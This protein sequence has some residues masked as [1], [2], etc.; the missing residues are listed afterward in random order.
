MDTPDSRPLRAAAFMLLASS[1][2]AASTLFAKAAGTATWLASGGPEL[3]F[4]QV[5]H[6]RFLF[7]FL[8]IAGLS[9]SLRLRLRGVHWP[10]HVGRTLCGWA[11]VS[12]MFG[13]VALIPLPDATALSFLNPVFAMIF[14]VLLLHER[15][16]RWRWLAAAIAFGGAMILLRPG[17]EGLQIGAVFALAAAVILGLEITLI[18]RLS[19]REPALQILLVNNGLGLCV[20]TLAVALVWQMPT[21]GQWPVLA[22]VGL[23]MVCAQACFIQA[24]KAADASLSVPFTYTVLIF[25]TLYD[26]LVFNVFP[27]AVS[28]LGA[29]V[30]L[31]GAALLAWREAKAARAAK[32]AGGPQ[33]PSRP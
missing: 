18:K 30:I 25:S 32:A 2:I 29:A 10:L 8:V 9:A 1:L 19:G 24:M 31:A 26:F 23:A 22:G 16:G 13:A 11:G 28:W 5:S 3:H 7:A 20:A 4:L 15:V 27:D 33:D 21:A 6:A 12:L 17:A 14:A